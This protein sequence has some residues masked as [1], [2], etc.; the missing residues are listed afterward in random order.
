MGCA[1]CGPA[2]APAGSRLLPAAADRSTRYRSSI[3][4]RTDS[5]VVLAHSRAH[6]HRIGFQQR[7]LGFRESSLHGPRPSEKRPRQRVQGTVLAECLRP[8]AQRVLQTRFRFLRP[9]QLQQRAAEIRQRS[10][11]CSRG[12]AARSRDRSSALRAGAA[13]LPRTACARERA[14]PGRSADWRRRRAARDAPCG[15]RPARSRR[16]AGLRRSG[17]DPSAAGRDCRVASIVSRVLRP[18]HALATGRRPRETAARRRPGRRCSC[19]A[20][21]RLCRWRMYCGWSLPRVRTSMRS[22]SRYSR[23]AVAKSRRVLREPRQIVERH[24]EVLV[25]RARAARR[26][27][28]GTL[29]DAARAL[30]SSPLRVQDHAEP[31]QARRRSPGCR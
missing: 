1:R 19:S 27:C 12:R 24:G 13:P 5:G 17:R 11:P 20:V 26:G 10:R 28:A 14:G 30:L 7:R 31:A 22:A 4:R 9:V 6:Q 29:R 16:S 23:S 21:A 8:F 3:Q 18:E 15:S 2:P 25:I